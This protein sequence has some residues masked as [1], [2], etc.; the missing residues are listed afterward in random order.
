MLLI[1]DHNELH[2]KINI[3]IFINNACEVAK[4]IEDLELYYKQKKEKI[5]TQENFDTE[6][7]H[8]INDALIYAGRVL[9]SV[10]TIEE[11]ID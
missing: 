3:D 7:E 1:D 11:S 2:K 4:R 9:D 5:I 8:I 10:D 6:F